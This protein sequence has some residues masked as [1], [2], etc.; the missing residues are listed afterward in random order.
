MDSFG[1]KIS[2]SLSIVGPAR[3]DVLPSMSILLPDLP[4]TTTVRAV[5]EGQIFVR[6]PV[7]GVLGLLEP[8]N[9]VQP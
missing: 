1:V 9:N 4:N 7:V 5:L 6:P 8:T 3:H 2:R